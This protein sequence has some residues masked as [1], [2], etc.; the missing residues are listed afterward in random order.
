MLQASLAHR[1]RLDLL[2]LGAVMDR[3]ETLD[4]RVHLDHQVCVARSALQDRLEL[5]ASLASRA[6]LDSLDLLAH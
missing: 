4:P 6:T 5:V 2:D 1:V 3:L